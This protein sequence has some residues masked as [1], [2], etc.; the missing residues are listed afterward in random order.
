MSQH[1]ANVFVDATR[2]SSHE[3]ESFEQE[4]DDLIYNHKVW[5]SLKDESMEKSYDGPDST[6][7]FDRPG[8]EPHEGPDDKQNVR[9]GEDGWRQRVVIDDQQSQQQVTLRLNSA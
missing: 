8:D 7:Y 6:Y 5:F 9:L 4:L 1:L 2:R 3:F